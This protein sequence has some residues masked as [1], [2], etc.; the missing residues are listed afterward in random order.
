MRSIPLLLA[1]LVTG[2]AFAGE[3]KRDRF[4]DSL[5]DGAVARLG[6]INAHPGVRSIAFSADGKTLHT[7]GTSSVREWD[8]TTGRVKRIA[9]IP[10]TARHPV[11]AERRPERISEDGRVGIRIV[12]K[13]IEVVELQPFKVR[14]RAPTNDDCVRALSPDGRWAILTCEHPGYANFEVRILNL[15]SGKSE[16]WNDFT[17]DPNRFVFSPDNK[18]VATSLRSKVGGIQCRHLVN[19]R[20]RTFGSNL[21]TPLAFS[22]DSKRIV[23]ARNENTTLEVWDVERG[24]PVNRSK[25]EVGAQYYDSVAATLNADGSILASCR[26]NRIVVWDVATGKKIGSWAG[27]ASCMAFSPDGKRLAGSNQLVQMWNIA[28]GK[29]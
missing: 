23:V 26:N 12:G 1:L 19:G 5:P 3:P 16:K 9:S 18:L 14:H 28:T 29:P 13:Q 11:D 2:P 21:L 10:H 8:M 15:E 4:G 6:T 7:A 27:S 25:I 24:E 22:A 17:G 20:L